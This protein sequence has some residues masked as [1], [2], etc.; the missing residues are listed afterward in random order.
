MPRHYLVAISVSLLALST[1]AFAGPGDA[2]N[3]G[4]VVLSGQSE[5]GNRPRGSA[6]VS[7]SRAC[8]E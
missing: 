7:A 5:P 3:S 6:G 8:R 1:P 4:S 2:S